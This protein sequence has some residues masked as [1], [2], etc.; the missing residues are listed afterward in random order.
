MGVL[1]DE[2]TVDTVM[3][4]SLVAA[5]VNTSACDDGYIAVIAYVEIII[6]HLG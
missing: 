3:L 6:N 4:G 2:E 5:I 1:A